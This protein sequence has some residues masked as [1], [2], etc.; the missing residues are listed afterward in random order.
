MYKQL[1][2]YVTNAVVKPQ[3]TRGAQPAAAGA[4]QQL[5][6]PLPR[7]EAGPG[8]RREGLQEWLQRRR[9]QRQQQQQEEQRRQEQQRAGVEG[10]GG[11]HLE[12]NMGPHFALEI[13]ALLRLGLG[14]PAAAAAGDPIPPVAAAANAA[15]PAVPVAAPAPA[16]DVDPNAPVALAADADVAG[17][18]V[19]ADAVENQQQQQ[20]QQQ[21]PAE[22]QEPPREQ[23]PQPHQQ[24]QQGQ[25]QRR[26]GD[27]APPQWEDNDLAAAAARTIQL[28]GS[29]L[30]RLLGGALAMPTI[31]RVM[32]NILLRLSHVL[33]L[34]RAIIAPRPLR[35]FPPAGGGGGGALG[36]WSSTT[37]RLR[38]FAGGGAVAVAG[39]LPGGLGARVLN[40]LFLATSQ[41]WA[42]S[43]PVW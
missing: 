23:V 11:G 19:E 2:K 18:N 25:E 20:Q 40:V 28:T 3:E 37:E 41:E 17:A 42:T 4:R 27:A 1:R 43:D 24:Q 15:L 12:L 31:A 33:P 39:G 13:R 21:P 16:P 6:L 30:G 32:G 22:A 34:V 9:Q 7:E 38:L 29:S 36:L 26:E 35:H 10:E 5:Q 14:G 8:R